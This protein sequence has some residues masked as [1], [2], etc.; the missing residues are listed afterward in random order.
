MLKGE[1][2]RVRAWFRECVR[3]FVRGFVRA[4]VS[5]Q[6]RG[7]VVSAGHSSSSVEQAVVAV[8]KGGVSMLTHLFNAMPQGH[9]AKY[10]LRPDA[11]KL[12]DSLFG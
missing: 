4:C 10:C 1:A 3:G 9:G 7:V 12:F 11:A 5:T 6:D 8:E 2:E